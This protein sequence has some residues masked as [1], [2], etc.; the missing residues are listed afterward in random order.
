VK[1]GARAGQPGRA[2]SLRSA[3]AG[4][5]RR[6][7]LLA[8]FAVAFG[9]SLV[10]LAVVGPPS[11]HPGGRGGPQPASLVAFPL[12][13]A[14]VGL[15]GVGLTGLTGGRG[16]VAE[17]L[18]GVRRWR[19]APADCLLAVVGPPAC[20]LAALLLLRALA[21]PAFT[22]NFFP[23]GLAFGV[24]AGFLEELG[25]TG[26]AYP[27]M[28]ARLGP[29][30]GALVLGLAW[31]L[32]HLPVVDSLGA[33]S[34]HGRALPLFFLAFTLVLTSLRLLIAWAYDRTGS[35]LLAQ[36]THASSTGFLVVLGAAHVTPAQEALW[37]GLYGALLGVVAAMAWA[38]R[39]A[40][41]GPTPRDAAQAR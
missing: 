14:T 17:L 25:W 13:V 8:Y 21:G 5:V 30:R 31:A 27:R 35:L 28:Q 20:I 26:F 39:P 23:V 38:R 7:P 41:A 3:V 34:P 22:P 18:R 32:W 2:G 37:Y 1:V 16:A 12:M 9:A 24:V 36:C 10:A 15:A 6:S 19:V 4:R 40:P 11:L 33:A 29:L